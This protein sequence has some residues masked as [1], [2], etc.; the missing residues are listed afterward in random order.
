MLSK[1]WTKKETDK[2]IRLNSQGLTAAQIHNS[3]E[4]KS[5]NSIEHKMRNLMLKYQGKKMNQYGGQI[6]ERN[7]NKDLKKLEEIIKSNE[8]HTSKISDRTFYGGKIRFGAIADTHIGSKWERLDALNNFYDILEK[9]KIKVVYH[10]GNYVDGEFYFNKYEV[11]THGF[12]DMIEN[13]LKKYPKRKGIETYFVDGDDHEGWWMQREGIRP[14][15]VVEERQ[16]EFDRKDLHYLG[17][18]EADIRIKARHGESIMR[19]IHAGGGTAYAESYSTQKMV[20]SFQ[21]GEKPA[22]LLVGHYHKAIYHYPRGVHVLQLGCFQD[23]TRFMRK[24]KIKANLGGWIVEMNQSPTG[25]INRFKAEFINYYDRK[26]YIRH[27]H[28]TR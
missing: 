21:E 1:P 2:L 12:D 27:E 25:E 8:P 13:F 16:K 23:Q 26:F 18:Q 28:E 10:G 19:L 15:K 3:F 11:Y 6:N 9:E 7:E 22:I 5:L 17:Y 14:G 20:E 24:Q 4:H